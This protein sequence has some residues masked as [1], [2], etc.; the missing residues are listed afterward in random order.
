MSIAN[1]LT[2]NTKAW[3]DL[4]INS[5]QFPT[6]DPFVYET[7]DI[8]IPFKGAWQF[9]ENVNV[10]I[11]RA[12][13]IVQILLTK[14][15]GVTDTVGRITSTS[16]IPIQYRPV[17]QV[18]I[19]L[20]LEV[21]PGSAGMGGIVIF[22][23]GIMQVFA[24]GNGSFSA[25]AGR[26]WWK[27]ITLSY[28]INGFLE[29]DL[30]EVTS[31]IT[32]SET[33][34]TGVINEIVLNDGVLIDQVL[35]QDGCVLMN[36]A[37]PLLFPSP[38]QG[39]IFEKNANID[40]ELQ[41]QM[42]FLD[43]F[44]RNAFY[45]HISNDL[46]PFNAGNTYAGDG[47][48]IYQGSLIVDGF[49]F[50]QISEG[51]KT[52]GIPFNS[53]LPMSGTNFAFARIKPFRVQL[54]KELGTGQFDNLLINQDVMTYRND[55]EGFAGSN[56]LDIDNNRILLDRPLSI[57]SQIIPVSLDLLVSK[58]GDMLMVLEAD[59]AGGNPNLHPDIFMVSNARTEGY[60]IGIDAN[61]DSKVETTGNFLI[62]PGMVLDV[63]ASGADPQIASPGTTGLNCRS[64]DSKVEIAIGL[65]T[66]LIENLAPSDM[67]I[68]SNGGDMILDAPGG[69]VLIEG[70]IINGTG[71]QVDQI[72]EATPA[73]GVDFPDDINT[74]VINERTGASGVTIDSVLLKDSTINFGQSDLGHY[75]EATHVSDISGIWAADILAVSFDLT[76]IGRIVTINL[77]IPANAVSNASALINLVTPIPADFRPTANT[78]T[79]AHINDN[80]VSNFGS[81]LISAAGVVTWSASSAGALFAGVG[82]S[83][84]LG[85]AFSWII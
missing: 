83:G 78:S 70:A 64:S 37:R 63:F 53:A 38:D 6:G 33:I 45:M 13:D 18:L 24:Q 59:S 68:T 75:Q 62:R 82:N 55:F 74:N 42:M 58:V 15:V 47:G 14:K 22:S 77:K 67:L 56:L 29:A 35:L 36:C 69:D 48:I 5:I 11:T 49:A 17:A 1:L 66:N 50:N 9:S 54:R 61:G 85:G 76:R 32:I 81:T 12:G 10:K 7:E 19:P 23:N 34:E 44:G 46:D 30:P 26:G 79:L 72:N 25:G 65:E 20:W 43:P 21:R 84:L 73:N 52:C 60:Q 4:K 16:P 57:N 2:N 31:T 40:P 3:A 41:N 8:V 80:T 39:L 27:D 71:L 51:I 28:S